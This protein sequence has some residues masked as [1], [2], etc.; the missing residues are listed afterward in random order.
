[1]KAAR[2]FA[3]GSFETFP[4]FY[5][6]KPVQ[7][8]VI[9]SP[10]RCFIMSLEDEIKVAEKKQSTEVAVSLKQKIRKKI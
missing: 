2:D 5:T 9:S 10:F 6:P 1:M 3:S 8:D 7:L 4:R